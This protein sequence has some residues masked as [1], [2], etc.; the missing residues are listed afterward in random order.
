[1]FTSALG[2][3]ILPKWDDISTWCGYSNSG[4]IARNPLT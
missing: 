3:D 1:L 4:R 2:A